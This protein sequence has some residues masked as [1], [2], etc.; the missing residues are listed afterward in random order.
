LW[1]VEFEEQ[2]LQP[3]LTRQV[4]VQ[5]YCC[6]YTH[7][8]WKKFN[9]KYMQLPLLTLRSRGSSLLKALPC[10]G[11]AVVQGNFGGLGKVVRNRDN[12]FLTYT[13]RNHNMNIINAVETDGINF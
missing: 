3:I 1:L 5:L 10:N 12:H 2:T 8:F 11:G 6:N 4:H 13:S 9:P 7:Q